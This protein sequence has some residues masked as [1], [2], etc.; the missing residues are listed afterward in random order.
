MTYLLCT[1][2]IFNDF[3]FLSSPCS[4][5]HVSVTCSR[6]WFGA[7][8]AH[9]HLWPTACLSSL[10][11]PH[12]QSPFQSQASHSP[13]YQLPLTQASCDPA[14]TGYL[15]GLHLLDGTQGGPFVVQSWMPKGMRAQRAP[16]ALTLQKT[17][18]AGLALIMQ[19]Y[20]AGARIRSGPL[21]ARRKLVMNAPARDEVWQKQWQSL[22][23]FPLTVWW[24][25]WGKAQSC[26]S[27]KAF[28]SSFH[29]PTFPFLVAAPL[30]AIFSWSPSSSS[31]T[32]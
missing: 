5:K 17:A 16:I 1:W 4:R 7:D 12:T 8:L 28:K 21:R 18:L 3:F 19:L 25:S 30:F 27:A 24:H 2:I 22:E 6:V 10:C 23:L 26:L 13:S 9:P 31:R 20:G 15:T 14:T 32:F 11:F 29:L